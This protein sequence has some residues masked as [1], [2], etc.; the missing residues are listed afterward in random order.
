MNSPP[1]YN[2]WLPL[3]THR[4][5]KHKID[6]KLIP[7]YEIC[8]LDSFEG[9][10]IKSKK[11]KT[12]LSHVN[13]NVT[14][15][16]EGQ[17]VKYLKSHIM[18]ASAY[19]DQI[20]LDLDITVDHIDFNHHN[21]HITNLQWLSRSDN[22]KR[23]G[24]LKEKTMLFMVLPSN[25]EWKPYSLDN[26]IV[27]YISNYGRVKTPNGCISIGSKLRDKKYRN[28]NIRYHD[29]YH[30]LCSKKYYIHQLVWLAFHNDYPKHLDIMHDDNAPLLED[31]SYR[32]WLQD[33]TIGTRSENMFDYHKSKNDKPENVSN[34]ETMEIIQVIQR[35]RYSMLSKDLSLPIGFWIQQAYKKKGEVVVVDIKR[36]K[37]NNKHLYWKSPSSPTLSIY[38][39]IEIAKKFVRWML[40]KYPFLSD[41][42]DV[43]GCQEN[44]SHLNDI[45]QKLL[46]NKQFG[47]NHYD[48][49]MRLVK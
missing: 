25:E 41:Y 30:I 11:R 9:C 12:H 37:H 10:I 45:E 8:F 42:C 5:T 7:E 23:N 36:A 16:L 32:N 6:S 15:F 47:E 39:K 13:E 27:Y 2:Q 21:N 35:P 49:F 4:I 26:Q 31:G 34:E 1:P 3:V 33:L 20:P 48:P 43:N 38:L 29:E 44:I 46:S 19:P 22:C 17:K 24:P 14:L 28:I 40:T 18:L